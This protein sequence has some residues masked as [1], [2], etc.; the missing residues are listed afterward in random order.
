MKKEI[1]EYKTKHE[2]GFIHSEIVDLCKHLGI[3]SS[4]VYEKI[5]VHTCMM[6]DGETITYP[7]DVDLGIR[8]V[9]E[10]RDI[11]IIEFD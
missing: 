3:S 2:E 8:C 4:D 1:A 10:D 5:G 6:I 11:N 7:Q 9:L